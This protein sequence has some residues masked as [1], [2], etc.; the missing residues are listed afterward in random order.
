[1]TTTIPNPIVVEPRSNLFHRPEKTRYELILEAIQP[2]SHHDADSADTGNRL[3]FNRER[4]PLEHAP[5]GALPSQAEIDVFAARHPVPADLVALFDGMSLPEF[6][7]L[8]Y[9]KLFLAIYGGGS[10][11]GL[12]TGDA[13]YEMLRTRLNHA[14]P[15]SYSQRAAPLR[16]IWSGLVDGLLLPMW[17]R[18][19]DADVLVFQSLPI[20][21]QYLVRPILAAHGHVVIGTAR[22]W[23]GVQKR[24]N[25][26]YA[27]R[28]GVDQAATDSTV[29]HWSAGNIT[30]AGQGDEAAPPF[31]EFPALTANSIRGGFIRRPSWWHLAAA[32]RLDAA[33]PGLGDLPPGGEGIFENGGNIATGAKQ[34]A[35]ALWLAQQARQAYPSLALLGGV[36]DA[37]DLGQSDLAVGCV[38]I[39]RENARR[40]AGTIA[41]GHAATRRS[42]FDMLDTVTHVRQ[43]DSQGK[44][45]MIFGFETLAIGSR[46]LVSFDLRHWTH[47]RTHGALV[48]AM[49]TA[50]D[51]VGS[52]G[53]QSARGY[54][55]IRVESIAGPDEARRAEYLEIYESYLHEN[56]D[57]L[58]Q[59]LID[60][61]L[62]TG[63]RVLS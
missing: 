61:T 2:I 47:P 11:D 17:P 8:A 13:R 37:F 63:K 7:A 31:L 21:L 32:M 26:V 35:G 57:A 49:R 44:G 42:V 60:G 51:A 16:A 53:G 9:I 5:D 55:A 59:G 4:M 6:V 20:G 43:E 18:D 39:C 34:E 28:A 38:L 52:I 48:A 15:R 62:T 33:L 3:L 45:Q 54:G 19:Y 36:T 24:Q 25:A 30:G 58:R 12:F 46:F 29:L 40:L 50:V 56:R 23:L 27:E 10:G 41:E 14:V 22:E 1:M